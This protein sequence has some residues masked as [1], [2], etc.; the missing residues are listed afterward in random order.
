[1]ELAMAEPVIEFDICLSF[2]GEDRDYVE[3]VASCLKSLGV[4]VFY[5]L[6]EQTSLWGK[7]LYVHLDEVYR[8]KARFCVVFISEHY[9]KKLWTNH[10][11]RSAQARAF[12]ENNEYLLPARFDDTEIPGL[13]PTV[14]Y[15][16]LKGLTSEAFAERVKEKLEAKDRAETLGKKASHFRRIYYEGFDCSHLTPTEIRKSLGNLWLIGKKVPWRG[17]IAGGVY[18]LSNLR[19][20]DASLN[21]AIRYY[22]QPANRLVDLGDCRASVRVRIEPPN[23]SHSGA[24]LIFRAADDGSTYY[25]LFLHPGNSVSLMEKRSGKLVVLWSQE[26]P[27]T[28]P[29]SFVGLKIVGEGPALTL[30]VNDSPVHTVTD[31]A[32]RSGSIG[33]IVWSIGHY[34]FDDFSIYLRGTGTSLS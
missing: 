5:D 14:G 17:S 22:E 24:G 16:S 29:G 2:A 1:M 21:N 4:R 9:S 15:I 27:E 6:Y 3:K 23:D 34:L 8:K 12:Q 33:T 25:A 30:Y 26:I 28:A 32:L 31:A 7:D 20:T 11:R 18:R 10:E 13:P 19:K